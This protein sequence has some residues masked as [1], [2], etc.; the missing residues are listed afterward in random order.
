LSNIVKASDVALRIAAAGRAVVQFKRVTVCRR[1][2]GENA[3][4][5]ASAIGLAN[6]LGV[7]KGE[8]RRRLEDGVAD[9]LPQ[10]RWLPLGQAS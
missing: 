10:V 6:Q 1:G 9:V 2:H 7:G 5:H 8:V 4:A 3:F